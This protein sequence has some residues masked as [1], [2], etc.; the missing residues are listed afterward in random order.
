[1]N[2]FKQ[3]NIQDAKKLIDQGSITI[4]DIRDAASFEEAHIENAVSVTDKNV[5][6]FV[7]KVDKNKPLL[8]YCFHGMTSQSA[9]QYFKENGIKTTYSM[10]GGFE[11]WRNTYPTVATPCGKE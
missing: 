11:D 6:E 8:C 2:S 7:S 1:M 9:A 4:V 5:E 10:D 3:V